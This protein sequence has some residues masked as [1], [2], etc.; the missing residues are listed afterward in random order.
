MKFD[1][2]ILEVWFQDEFSREKVKLS[3]RSGKLAYC[4]TSWGWVENVVAQA[5]T[6]NIPKMKIAD[7]LTELNCWLEVFCNPPV[8]IL[9]HKE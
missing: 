1:G 9:I 4:K 5:L 3:G 7:Y 2:N 6:V 8:E